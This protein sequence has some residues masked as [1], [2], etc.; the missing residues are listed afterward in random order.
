MKKTPVKALL[1]Q[2]DALVEGYDLE[3]GKKW[4][5][6]KKAIAA[7][8]IAVA[9]VGAHA[10]KD[11][12]KKLLPGQQKAVLTHDQKIMQRAQKLVKSGMSKEG[13]ELAASFEVDREEFA[14]DLKKLGDEID[15]IMPALDD[16]LQQATKEMEKQGDKHEARLRPLPVV[17]EAED[18][19]GTLDALELF[20]KDVEDLVK[21]NKQNG[22]KDPEL[23]KAAKDLKA[24]VPGLT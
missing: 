24:A 7:A 2:I 14:A 4:P 20:A 17:R 18:G 9:A 22:L 16:V 1:E 21:L 11:A 23:E 6:W 5:L 12:L 10:E 15:A 19:E 3:E 13:A 8:L